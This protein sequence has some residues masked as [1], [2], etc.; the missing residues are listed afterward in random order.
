MEK[1]KYVC[2][3]S[4]KYKEMHG[5]PPVVD[6]VYKSGRVFTFGED[7]LPRT[8]RAFCKTH[9]TAC[10]FDTLYGFSIMYR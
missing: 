9:K 5:F 6:V 3:R 1:I 10:F 8:V 4:W 7:D 2:F